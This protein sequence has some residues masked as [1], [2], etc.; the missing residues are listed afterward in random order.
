M[1]S[2]DRRGALRARINALA[3]LALVAG[4]SQASSATQQA[5]PAE[6]FQRQ[7]KPVLVRRCL[8]CHGS[9]QSGSLDLR[10]KQTMLKGG[11]SGHVVEPGKPDESLLIEYVES[12]EMPPAAPLPA[13]EIA[14]LRKWIA[15][16]AYFPDARLDP[17]SVSTEDRAGFDW[18]SLQPLSDVEPPTP[19]GLPPAWTHNP[20]DRFVYAQLEARGLKPAPRADRRTLIRRASY[21]LTGLPPTSE[22]IEAFERDER[23]DAY[24]RLIDRLLASPNYGEH[25]GRH[26]LDVVRF[27][28][29][30]GFERNQIIDNAWP[31]RDYVIRSLNEDRPFDQ[32]VREHLAGDL[33]AAERPDAVFGT[34]FLVC[35]PYDDVANQD[36][37]QA[38]QI[39]ANTI[40]DMIRATSETFLGLTVGCARCHNHKFDPIAQQDYYSFYATFAGVHHGSREVSSDEERQHR[41]DQLRPLLDRQAQIEKAQREL[42]RRLEEEAERRAAEIARQ[43]TRP[44]IDRRGVEEILEPVRAR[45]VRLSVHGTDTNPRAGSGYRIDEFEIW[46]ADPE[47][48]NVALASQ[49][50]QATGKSRV[51]EDFASAY[52]ASLAIDG[53][54]GAPWIASGSELTIELK[55]PELIGRVFFSSDRTGAAG[56]QSIATF[57]GEYE[58]AVSLD[59]EQ[60]QQVAS[61]QSRKPVSAAHRK[62]RLV[63]N[64]ITRQQRRQQSELARQ[65]RQVKER[66]AQVKPLPQWWIGNFQDAPG[67]FHVFLGGN[68]RKPGDE[69]VPHSLGCLDET[70]PGYALEASLPESERRKRLAEWIVDPRNPLTPRV[71]ANR[72]WAYHFGTGIVDTPSDFGFMGGRPTHPELLDW[73]ARQVHA[74]GWRWKPMHRMIMLSETYQQSSAVDGAAKQVDAESRYLWRFPPRRLSAEEI[75]DSMLLVAGVLNREPGGPGFRLYHYMQDNVATYVPLDK[76]GPETYRRAV[77]HQNARATQIDLMTEYDLPDCAFAAPRRAST[78]TPLQALTMMNHSFT[79]DMAAA[80]AQRAEEAAATGSGGDPELVEL[81]RCVFRLALARAPRAAEEPAA[82]MLVQ[83]YGLVALCRAMFNTNEFI[84]LD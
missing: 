22:E 71:L 8:E 27:G 32:L 83:Q 43:W 6:F 5:T 78:T 14:V 63:D 29:S 49:G 56:D 16:G 46:T 38:A 40:D 24:E 26:W 34:T 45:F 82:T 51:A 50:A 12:E 35:G 9:D 10:H 44:P 62:K 70:A 33:L 11:D 42:Q 3:T 73:L 19:P 4:L 64:V 1:N 60:W 28:E 25:W 84:Y 59:G 57:V 7:V 17:F 23:P 65:L 69:V 21:D 39:R 37:V 80:L 67:P 68:P 76:F 2:G 30:I 53:M 47:P 75:R 52:S 61:S 20:I 15:D 72:L 41:G 77:Y 74:V 36:P 13:A 55:R 79:M 66:I 18:W 31:F 54:F 81:V 58:L 48:R